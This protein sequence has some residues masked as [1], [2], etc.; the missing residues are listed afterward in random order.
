MA[1]RRNWFRN[2]FDG[3][4]GSGQGFR[5]PP[6]E[7]ERYF[8]NGEQLLYA[9]RRHPIVLEPALVVWFVS[10]ALLVFA[11]AEGEGPVTVIAF[12]V[13]AGGSLWLV[14]RFSQWW[15]RRYV[16]TNTRIL[17]IEGVLSRRV[18]G[19]PLKLVIDTNY[20]RTLGG[21]LFGYGDLELNL[22]GQ[23]GLRML[24][25]L[26][27][28]DVMYRWIVSLIGDGGSP[29]DGPPGPHRPPRPWGP[30]RPRELPE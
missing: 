5:S 21:R 22:S 19:V 24:T 13:F 23:P 8:A 14:G 4:T 3:G 15:M 18:R 25:M 2:R 12:V 6:G 26:P 30:W 16:L 20:H 17:L 29:S 10:G 27:H 7:P 28:P 1:R 11:L 9:C